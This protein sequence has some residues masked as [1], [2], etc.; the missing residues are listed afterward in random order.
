M[1][2]DVPGGPGWIIRAT[3]LRPVITD[4]AAFRTGLR[5]DS[6]AEPIEL[7]WTGHAEAALRH[8]EVLEQT[9][10]VRALQADCRRDLGDTDTAVSEYD[11]LVSECAGTAREATMR[12]HRGKALL[13]AGRVD[14]A[15]E[16]F[17][18][19]VALRRSADETHQASALQALA[20]AR[21]RQQDHTTGSDKPRCS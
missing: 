2:N 20:V 7:L 5:D 12:Q 14:L 3:D 21:A 17:R 8:L 19:A 18:A 10:R 13:A 11:A 6:L 16:D 4:L 1:V 15:V 9:P